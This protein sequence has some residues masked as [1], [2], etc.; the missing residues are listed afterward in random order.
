[1]INRIFENV[2]P[3]PKKESDF[4]DFWGHVRETW[5][6]HEAAIEKLTGTE[7][8]GF[9]NIVTSMLSTETNNVF[10]PCAI[11]VGFRNLFY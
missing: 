9:R 1:M 10:S 8:A 3:A 4:E 6:I 5:K 11:Y 7:V 2:N